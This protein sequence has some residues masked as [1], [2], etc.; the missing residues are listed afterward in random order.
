MLC[1][2]VRQSQNAGFILLKVLPTSVLQD[3]P[4]HFVAKPSSKPDG[5]IDMLKWGC[6]VPGKT[7]TDWEGGFYPVTLYFSEDYP[8]KAPLAR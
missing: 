7:G 1:G 5:S 2:A 8:T 3:H 6:I 4:L